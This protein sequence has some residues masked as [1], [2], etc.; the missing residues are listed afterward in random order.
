M[1]SP[2]VAV[3]TA[4]GFRQLTAYAIDS[5]RPGQPD[6]AEGQRL[7]V[8]KYAVL[9]Y[10]VGIPTFVSFLSFNPNFVLLLSYFGLIF[11]PFL[12]SVPLLSL[13]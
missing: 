10:N 2:L 11:V 12:S 1:P 6:N 13:S 3:Q 8:G 9:V 4:I 5:E 7:E